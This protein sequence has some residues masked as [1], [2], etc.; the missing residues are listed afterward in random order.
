MLPAP[1]PGDDMVQSKLASFLTTIL[2]G[3]PVPVKNLKASQ[4]SITAERA[5]DQVGESDYRRHREILA[6]RVNEAHS[7]FQHLS[8]FLVD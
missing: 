7:V 6:S 8:L 4:L 3:E 5:L 1:V 2:A